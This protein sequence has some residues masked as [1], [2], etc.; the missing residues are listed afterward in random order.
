ML[1]KKFRISNG[2]DYNYIFKN[3]KKIQAKFIIVFMAANHLEYDR[4]GIVTSKKVGNAVLRNLAK[5]RM[6][7]IIQTHLSEIKPGF[8]LVIVAR[9]NINKAS[10]AALEKDFLHAVKKAGLV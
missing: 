8:D 6:R 10:Y 5:R 1:N 2:E 7:S 9:F 3:G 4:F